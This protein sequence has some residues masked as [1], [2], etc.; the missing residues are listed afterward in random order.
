[1][2]KFIIWTP[3]GIKLV[4]QDNDMVASRYVQAAPQEFQPSMEDK[5]IWTDAIGKVVLLLLVAAVVVARDKWILL[6]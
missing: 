6:T 1:M 2:K 3:F 5:K 4:H